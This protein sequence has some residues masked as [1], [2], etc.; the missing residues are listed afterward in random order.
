MIKIA[1]KYIADTKGG[2]IQKKKLTRKPKVFAMNG[3]L[4]LNES[5]NYSLK[6]FI[7]FKL[8][9]QFSFIW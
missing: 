1:D 7:P 6:M 2:A 5:R 8:K 9:H 3:F 4:D